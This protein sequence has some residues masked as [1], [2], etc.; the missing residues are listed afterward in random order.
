M[1]VFYPLWLAYAFFSP[2][3][4]RLLLLRRRS[5]MMN[6]SFVWACVQHNINGLPL[7]SF[8]HWIIVSSPTDCSWKQQIIQRN[9]ILAF[10]R[11][12]IAT[13]S[14][15]VFAACTLLI[16]FRFVFFRFSIL[17]RRFDCHPSTP[18]VRVQRTS[19][20]RKTYAAE[21]FTHVCC[22]RLARK[23][24]K[25]IEF[26]LHLRH[27]VMISKVKNFTNSVAVDRALYVHLQ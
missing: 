12:A 8:E 16:S 13:M 3:C 15:F 23:P 19:N 1:N 7:C 25:Y 6:I 22:P 24:C 20:F 2:I 14:S 11:I 21:Y 10:D 4:V 26:L 18:M 9:N 27:H 5:E 17:I